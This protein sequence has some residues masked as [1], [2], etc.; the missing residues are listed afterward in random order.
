MGTLAR[1]PRAK[2]AWALSAPS[3]QQEAGARNQHVPYG[4]LGTHVSAQVVAGVSKWLMSATTCGW[5]HLRSIVTSEL[6]RSVSRDER[7]SLATRLTATNRPVCRHV[8]ECT[9]EKAPVPM[10]LP[11]Q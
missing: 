7:R 9:V 1:L 2:P 6:R 4:G 5:R 8:A 3:T 11:E 10:T